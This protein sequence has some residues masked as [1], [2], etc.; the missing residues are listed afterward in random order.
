MLCRSYICG[1]I[2]LQ[3]PAVAINV[4]CRPEKQLDGVL[5]GDRTCT[6][7]CPHTI[8]AAPEG[9]RQEEEASYTVTSASLTELTVLTVSDSSF[10]S[11]KRAESAMESVHVWVS[12]EVTVRPL[13]KSS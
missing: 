11:S 8:G 10:S 12:D 9:V 1:Y 2:R 5:I 7:Q 6:L 3:G 13:F 4:K